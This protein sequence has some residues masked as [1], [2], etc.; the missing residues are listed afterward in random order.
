MAMT[1]DYKVRD[2]TGNLVEGQLEGDSLALVVGKLREMGYLPLA[3]TPKTG[4]NV[5]RE[6]SIPGFTNRVKLNEIAVVTRQIATMIDSGLSV[7]RSLG[8]LAGQVENKEL[9]RILGEVRMEVERGSSLSGA[10]AKHPKVFNTLFVTMVQAGEAGGHLDSV[11]LELASTIEKQ[12]VLRR[13]VRSAMTYP[14]IVLSVMVVIFLALL[15]FIVPVF[16]K[17][18]ASLHAK[19]PLPTQVVIGIS[20]I[21]LSVWAV[22]LVAILVGG[23]VW[24]RRWIK[25]EYG[26]LKWDAFKLK[27]PIFGQLVHKVS[28][29]RLSHTLGSLIQAGVPILESLDIVSETAGNQVIGNVLLDAKAGVREG[30]ALA[31]TL[32]DHEEVIPALVT[33]MVEVGEQTGALDAML[34]KVG[35]FYDGEVEITVNNLTSMLEPIMTVFMGAGVGIMVISMYLPMFSYIKAVPTH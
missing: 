35:E 14:I 23:I 5:H 29:A 32:R 30:R 17:L 9:A 16:Q 2:R 15:I 3:V 8:I 10:C 22:L 19:L 21:V 28:L 27:P 6:I 25:T 13:K 33:Q 24:L 11:L 7:V 18:F 20:K 4:M 34:H 31:D 26:R 12:A 1:F